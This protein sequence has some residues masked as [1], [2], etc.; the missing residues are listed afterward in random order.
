MMSFGR[1]VILIKLCSS[2]WHN[3]M[4]I[5]IVLKTSLVHLFKKKLVYMNTISE[6]VYI[7]MHETVLPKS[8]TEQMKNAEA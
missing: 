7:L 6:T 8:W 1:Y 4:A 3:W 5:C 2:L